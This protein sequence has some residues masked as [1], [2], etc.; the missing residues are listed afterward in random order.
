M[1]SHGTHIAIAN[2]ICK[3]I[4]MGKNDFIF[5]NILPDILNGFIIKAPKNHKA[6]EETHYCDDTDNSIKLSDFT[7]FLNENKLDSDLKLGYCAHLLT[8]FY[9]NK[10][11][12]E[13]CGISNNRIKQLDL[14]VFDK[15][16]VSIN[17]LEVF[18]IDD[19]L[20]LK[21]KDIMPITKEELLL[22]KFFFDNY[23][24]E[25]DGFEGKEYQAFSEEELLIIYSECI[26]FV[27]DKLMKY[28]K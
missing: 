12:I 19:S 13:I 20:L 25:L 14:E 28:S 21:S 2:E 6:R 23:Q 24:E 18:E 8:D 4:K 15:Y 5:G 3:R 16:I 17:K 27:V 1:P 11:A 10:K 7:R 26:D 22:T 9:F